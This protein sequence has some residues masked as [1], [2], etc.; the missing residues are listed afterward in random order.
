MTTSKDQA[1]FLLDMCKTI[2]F[3]T[4]LGWRTTEGEFKRT[5]E[6]QKIYFDRGL[7][8]TLNSRHLV[9]MA[10]DLN[11]IRESD[12]LY[13]GALKTKAALGMLRPVGEFWESLSPLNRWGGNFDRDWSRDDSFHD[14]PHF[15]RLDSR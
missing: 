8:K 14:V 10:A 12:G 9:G 11:F 13:I 3:A 2:Q 6:Q 15:E 1:A 5:P 7:S 4:S